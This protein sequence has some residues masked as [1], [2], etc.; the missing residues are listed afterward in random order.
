MAVIVWCERAQIWVVPLERASRST[1]V[2]D[3][4]PA[5]SGETSAPNVLQRDLEPTL[6]K[7]ERFSLPGSNQWFAVR[8]SLMQNGKPFL[9]KEHA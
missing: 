4:D 9:E 8:V 1:S 3:P 7:R 5:F 6:V 2:Q